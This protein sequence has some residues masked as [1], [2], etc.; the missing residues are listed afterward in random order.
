MQII[1]IKNTYLKLQLLTKII[2]YLK[3]WYIAL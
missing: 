3:S 1:S 2:S